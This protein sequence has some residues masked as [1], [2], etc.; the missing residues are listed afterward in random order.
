[1]AVVKLHALV[2]F[3]L[4]ILF[5]SFASASS[6]TGLR[7]RTILSKKS[8]A[9]AEEVNVPASAAKPVLQPIREQPTGT[10]RGSITAMLNGARARTP[11]ADSTAS[12]SA[13]ITDSPPRLSAFFL[14]M[15]QNIP[16][17][18]FLDIDALQREE[19]AK[20]LENES[21]AARDDEEA[22][23]VAFAHKNLPGVESCASFYSVDDE[24]EDEPECTIEELQDSLLPSIEE[25]QESQAKKEEKSKQEEEDFGF[26]K[27]MGH[28]LEDEFRDWQ[29][30][31]EEQNFPEDSDGDFILID[32]PDVS[33]TV[34][35]IIRR[36]KTFEALIKSAKSK[37]EVV[38]FV[39]NV[40]RLLIVIV[41][42]IFYNEP[43]KTANSVF[44][45]GFLLPVPT[46]QFLS[47][48]ELVEALLLPPEDAQKNLL[49]IEQFGRQILITPHSLLPEP[50]SFVSA[51]HYHASHREADF[52]Q[53]HADMKRMAPIYLLLNRH[54]KMSR[55]NQVAS[56]GDAVK[57]EM[58]LLAR[59]SYVLCYVF[60]AQTGLPDDRYWQYFRSAEGY[61][62]IEAAAGSET[63]ENEDFVELSEAPL[64]YI[65]TQGMDRIAA[66]FAAKFDLRLAGPLALRF[67]ERFMP[68]ILSEPVL[69]IVCAE[70]EGDALAIVEE[71]LADRQ[72]LTN[73]MKTI[74]DVMKTC[75]FSGNIASTLHF[76]VAAGVVEMEEFV[77]FLL[78]QIPSTLSTSAIAII[79]AARILYAM[80]SFLKHFEP[81]KEQVKDYEHLVGVLF[82][83]VFTQFGPFM[84]LR[85]DEMKIMLEFARQLV[86]FMQKRKS[87]QSL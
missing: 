36:R 41:N 54:Y 8:K 64:K 72:Q 1:M 31:M 63:S 78:T 4:V 28:S 38:A 7:K 26:T 12:P 62:V 58:S 71:Y 9:S 35:E 68:R 21:K 24:E 2:L 17:P 86:P 19:E 33:D 22:T 82:E 57:E 48:F 42:K 5:V 59:T 80:P 11:S 25:A 55:M 84:V 61:G 50:A 18:K 76:P 45:D 3:L 51:K 39:D 30:R 70:I 13:P 14:E 53:I 43:P 66:Y 83:E 77:Q 6:A 27:L 20:R 34:Q 56:L 16:L 23:A 67:F 44:I 37:R 40:K 69:S 85:G 81:L 79:L 60:T 73:E 46:W 74:L 15:V 75:P 52:Y 29:V 32:R 49:K 87:E 47:D 65:F 10:W